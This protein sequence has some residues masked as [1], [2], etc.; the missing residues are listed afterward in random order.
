MHVMSSV[1]FFLACGA[2]EFRIG[3]TLTVS[4]EVKKFEHTYLKNRILA[5]YTEVLLYNIQMMN[6]YICIVKM[7]Y[8]IFI[9]NTFLEKS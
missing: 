5:P 2:L 7:K 8:F 4:Q 3:F 9:V 1:A 6:F